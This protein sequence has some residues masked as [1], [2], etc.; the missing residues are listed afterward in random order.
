MS[1][2]RL[3]ML[4]LVLVFVPGLGRAQTPEEP[5]V[6]DD[7]WSPYPEAGAA[8][9]STSGDDAP[10]EPLGYPGAPLP[11]LMEESPSVP[12]HHTEEDAPAEFPRHTAE[13]AP[14]GSIGDSAWDTPAEPRGDPGN[15]VPAEPLGDFSEDV[16]T[17]PLGDSAEDAP[18][19][20]GLLPASP[21][22]RFSPRLVQ[23]PLAVPMF[24][25]LL[26]V[27]GAGAA[28]LGGLALVEL[29]TGTECLRTQ[30]RMCVLTSFLVTMLSVSATAPVGAWAMGSLLGGE[31]K[32]WAAYLGSAM[33]MGIGVV[34]TMPTIAFGNGTA[35]AIAGP[36]GAV[37]GA[38]IGYEV[39][40]HF[41]R[42]KASLLTE[43]PSGVRVTPM[44]GATPGGSLVGGMA[45][46][47]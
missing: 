41:S 38:A 5:A 16:P 4:L 43:R 19:R 46:S 27:A 35:L 42:R 6:R 23:E 24:R 15:D 7:A 47:F 2:S 17:E 11:P 3:A 33:G 40:H 34:G 1:V 18:T 9:E 25:S 26:D 20:P 14:S 31:G 44:L 8:P 22:P 29:L 12:A 32:L 28:T 45:G 13:D 30:E 10:F 37:L 21:A 39:S 36:I